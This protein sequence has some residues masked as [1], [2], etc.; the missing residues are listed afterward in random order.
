ME[1]PV[2]WARPQ[3][4]DT[5]TRGPE[6]PAQAGR[7]GIG[8]HQ[9]EAVLAGRYQ[10]LLSWADIQ[11]E[12]DTA[13]EEQPE[14]LKLPR[15]NIAPRQSIPV[16]VADEAGRKLAPMR[17][18]FPPIWAAK[19]GK[20]PFNEPPIIN[21]R[22]EE[23]TKK[24]TWSASLRQRRCLLPATGFYEW[25]RRDGELFPILFAAPDSSML[26]FAGIWAPFDWTA[27]ARLDWPCAALLTVG[28]SPAVAPVHDRMP[29]VIPKAA[30]ARWLDP[31]TR[32]EDAVALLGP[33]PSLIPREVHTSLNR[34][35]TEGPGTQTANWT[36]T[37]RPPA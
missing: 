10:I 8:G 18:G 35:V 13:W 3:L 14:R 25:L 27:S 20:D 29:A 30:R 31:D 2:G 23:A 22:A 24:S 19:N 32:L 9:D 37:E 5:G 33:D 11:A 26:T 16:V 15:Y 36:W 28:P 7:S 17:W 6:R 21:A 4:P 34:W 12:V 1:Q